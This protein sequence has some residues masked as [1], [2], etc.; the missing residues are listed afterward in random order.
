MIIEEKRNLFSSVYLYV[1]EILKEYI[2]LS[3]FY[4]S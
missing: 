3:N 2:N 4:I 1:E